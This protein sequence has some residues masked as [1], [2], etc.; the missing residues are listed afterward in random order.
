MSKAQGKYDFSV[1]HPFK[2]K[3]PVKFMYK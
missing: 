1:Y 2:L 3:F